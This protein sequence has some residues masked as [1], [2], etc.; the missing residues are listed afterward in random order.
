MI[1]SRLLEGGICC[2]LGIEY[3]IQ[4][5]G[6]GMSGNSSLII[7]GDECCDEIAATIQ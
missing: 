4:Q 6:L 2:N 7:R 5:Y 3:W 1:R